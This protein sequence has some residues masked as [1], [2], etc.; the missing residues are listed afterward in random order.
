MDT[1]WPAPNRVLIRLGQYLYF[2]SLNTVIV[3]VI[4]Q[5]PKFYFYQSITDRS[6]YGL[7]PYGFDSLIWLLDTTQVQPESVYS[8]NKTSKL[9]LPK[10][11][12]QKSIKQDS[13]QTVRISAKGDM[14]GFGEA[15]THFSRT[16][17]A[18]LFLTFQVNKSDESLEIVPTIANE[19]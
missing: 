19:P 8:I 10:E 12:E 15:Y 16:S 4:A 17:P 5:S 1:I 18:K 13:L 9:I 11:I 14:I 2:E 6:F 7:L 3:D